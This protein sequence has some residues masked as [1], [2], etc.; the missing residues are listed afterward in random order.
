MSRR[1]GVI[2]YS[3]FESRIKTKYGR[4]FKAA[5]K[6]NQAQEPKTSRQS[7]QLMAASEANASS[8]DLTT[9]EGLVADLLDPGVSDTKRAEY[10]W[11]VAVHPHCKQYA[12]KDVP[13]FRYTH[14]QTNELLSSSNT[15]EEADLQLYANNAAIG[16]GAP[17]EGT[18][19]HT[20]KR[21]I[22]GGPHNPHARAGYSDF[23]TRVDTDAED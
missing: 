3:P 10:E 14:Y 12:A 7:S 2:P 15:A 22:H 5:A 19:Y 23:A 11:C 13:F 21:Y 9:L 4:R 17:V 20:Y 16:H 18:D 1:P 6:A 8:G